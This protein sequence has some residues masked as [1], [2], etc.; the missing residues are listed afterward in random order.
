LIHDWIASLPRGETPELA[1]V[2]RIHNQEQAA[3]AALV[4]AK[5]TSA[6]T[7]AIDRLLAAP[8]GALRLVTTIEAGK[9]PAEVRQLA[10]DRGLARQEPIIRDL[11]ERYVPEER[12]VKRLGT[13]IKAGDILA[14]RGDATRGKHLFFEAAG[15][16]CR[17]CHK[18][19]DLGKALG[20]DLTQIGKKHA[21]D[22]LLETILQPSKTI[23]PQFLSYL[24]ETAEGQVLSGLLASR[25]DSEIVLKQ[26]DGKEIRVAADQIERFAPQQKS[27]MPDLLLQEMTAQQVADLLAYLTALK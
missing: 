2:T 17:N 21:P 24:I 9:L 27:L 18:I 12:R 6:A 13:D 3:V 22:K 11:F 20:P 26:A 23:E 7:V 15:V 8:S 1:S 5:D 14:L 10:I 4:A 25:S 16:A 19:G